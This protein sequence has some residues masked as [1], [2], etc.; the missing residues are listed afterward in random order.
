MM[1]DAKSFRRLQSVKSQMLFI[2]V[3]VKAPQLFSHCYYKPYVRCVVSSILAE[4]LK[5][6]TI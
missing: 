6:V 4:L 5:S 1:T 3:T 2:A